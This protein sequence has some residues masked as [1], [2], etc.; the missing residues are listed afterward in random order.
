MDPDFRENVEVTWYEERPIFFGV[1]PLQRIVLS[2]ICLNSFNVKERV[3]GNLGGMTIRWLN[4]MDEK[5]IRTKEGKEIK[6]QKF[7]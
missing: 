2:D 1:V 4:E 3:E 7:V 6:V 5:G